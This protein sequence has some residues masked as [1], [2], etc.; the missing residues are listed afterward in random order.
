VAAKKSPTK[1]RKTPTK[2]NRQTSNLLRNPKVVLIFVYL[3]AVVGVYML[4]QSFA[5]SPVAR[6]HIDKQFV[7]VPERGLVWAGLKSGKANTLCDKLLEMVDS[8]GQTVG[9]THGPDPAPEGVNIKE[10]AAPLSTGETLGSYALSGTVT[11][12]GDGM[13]GNRVQAIYVHASDVADR[14]DTYAA[15]FQ[16]WSAN[17]DKTF[18]DSAAET[19]GTRSVRW[20]HDA[21]CNVAIARA[22]VSTTGDDNFSNMMSELKAQ[23]YNRT[24]RK[25]L[26]WSDA[27]VYCGIGTISY[28]D[29][30]AS[31]NVN[32]RGPSFGRVDTGCWGLNRGAEVHEL[33]H[34]LGGVQLS[35][36]HTTGGGHCVDENDRMCYADATGVVMSYICASAHEG[37][38]DC[39]HD[40]YFSTNPASD[41][42][43]ATHWNTANSSFLLIGGGTITPTPIS[44]DT[45]LPVVSITAPQDGATV[46]KRVT[47]SASSTDNVGVVKMEIYIDGYLKTSS[48]TASISTI[49]N[50]NKNTSTGAHII[51]VKSYDAAGNIGQTRITVYK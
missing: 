4:F 41:S 32:N 38:F 51:V 16:Q 30:A 37:L 49:W 27:S 6:E 15:S 5:Q 18:M 13:S 44:G 2:N 17:V 46:S 26:I 47:I 11:C 21:A 36:P 28:S 1:K 43:L 40:D 12:D 31:S 50:V 48:S 25:Y 29:T 7:E 33:M 8:H 24:D 9:C 3:F 22:T 39:G 10:P 19:G 23:G 42:Y 35:A 34:N 14:Y 20:V 45:T